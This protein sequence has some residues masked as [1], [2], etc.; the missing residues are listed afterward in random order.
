MATDIE[1]NVQDDKKS[2]HGQY[3][4][5][6]VGI[7]DAYKTQLSE[8]VTKKN[9]LKDKFFNCI[10]SIMYITAWTFAAVV[11]LSLLVMIIMAI[12][13]SD[14]TQILVGAIVSIIS[15]FTT[16]ILGI[17]KLPQIIA[18]YLFNKEEDKQMQEIIV[19][20]QKYELDADK[21]ERM[22]E[23]ASVDA[24]NTMITSS[25]GD[26]EMSNSSYI[27]SSNDDVES[28]NVENNI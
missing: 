15:S 1:N 14:S 26:M 25:D 17:Y 11:V 13:G 24:I 27:D 12:C 28:K 4:E 7:L 6:Y 10:K 22:R 3:T 19:N 8:S 21:T 20:I 23:K 2:T 9:E 18:D 16:L 5:A